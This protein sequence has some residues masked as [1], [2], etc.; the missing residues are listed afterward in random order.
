MVKYKIHLDGAKKKKKEEE[1]PTLKDKKINALEFFF[2]FFFLLHS[3]K[4]CI[5]ESAPKKMCG[6]LCLCSEFLIRDI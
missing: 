2:F 4:I 3:H 6:C 5:S 1:F